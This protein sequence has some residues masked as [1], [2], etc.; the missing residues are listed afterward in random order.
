MQRK[1]I[2]DGGDKINDKINDTIDPKNKIE[3]FKG[4]IHER[5]DRYFKLLKQIEMN[6]SSINKYNDI[7]KDCTKNI[8]KARADI[9]IIKKSLCEDLDIIK[10]DTDYD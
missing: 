10:G 1:L 6:K 5:I 7:M 2:N 4:S 9:A 3:I 8:N